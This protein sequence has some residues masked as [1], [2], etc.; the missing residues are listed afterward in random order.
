MSQPK[1]TPC[2]DCK[3][4]E[5]G[6]HGKCEKYKVFVEENRKAKSYDKLVNPKNLS[7]WSF[8]SW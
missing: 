6:C 3:D 1:I 8:G 5:V 2:K 7:P 4:R